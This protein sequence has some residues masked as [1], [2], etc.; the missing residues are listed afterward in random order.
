M[1]LTA[2]DF[3][4]ASFVRRVK[5]AILDIVLSTLTVFVFLP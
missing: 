2:L 3:G 1:L 4:H 5:V